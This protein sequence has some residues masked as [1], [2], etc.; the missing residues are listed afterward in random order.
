MYWHSWFIGEDISLENVSVL[1]LSLSGVKGLNNATCHSQ[2]ENFHSSCTQQVFLVCALNLIGSI[3]INVLVIRGV[4]R[5]FQR[6]GGGAQ[7][8]RLLTR[9]SC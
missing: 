1:D 9:L 4:A 7:S 2:E 3:L 6:G 5:I 8:Q